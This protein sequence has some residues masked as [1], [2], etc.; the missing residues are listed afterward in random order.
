[1]RLGE[2]VVSECHNPRPNGGEAV[3]AYVIVAYLANDCEP[4]TLPCRN[5]SIGERAKY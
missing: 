4:V 5:S 3:T 2:Q 1:M